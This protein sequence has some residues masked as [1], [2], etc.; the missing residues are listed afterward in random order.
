MCV[1]YAVWVCFGIDDGIIMYAFLE[2]FSHVYV[3]EYVLI[4]LF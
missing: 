4:F 2:Y 1:R 3:C